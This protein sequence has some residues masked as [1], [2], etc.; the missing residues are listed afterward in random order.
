MIN[1]LLQNLKS[2]AMVRC[3]MLAV[4]VFQG[5]AGWFLTCRLPEYYHIGSNNYKTDNILLDRGNRGF[6]LQFSVLAMHK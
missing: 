1:E 2:I 4:C 5:A 3:N 6:N